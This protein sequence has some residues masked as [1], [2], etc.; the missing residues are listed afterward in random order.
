MNAKE[1][2]QTIESLRKEVTQQ[3]FAI[4]DLINGDVHWIRS[5]GQK[6]GVIRPDSASGGVVIVWNKTCGYAT[7]RYLEEWVNSVHSIPAPPLAD[8]E[9]YSDW[10]VWFN[11]AS[12][13]QAYRNNVINVRRTV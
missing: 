4:N 7:T 3:F 13:V 5:G 12:A 6:V 1:K 2:N 11:L 10:L 8:H 9:N